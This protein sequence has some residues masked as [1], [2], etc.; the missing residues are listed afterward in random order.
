MRTIISD[1]LTFVEQFAIFSEPSSK[2]STLATVSVEIMIL[3]NT[4]LVEICF[5]F[6]AL[7][8]Q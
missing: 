5:A 7:D 2:L 8:Q 1:I 6:I 3:R 4:S